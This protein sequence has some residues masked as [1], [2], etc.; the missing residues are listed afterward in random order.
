MFC[1]NC[2]TENADGDKFC[3]SCGKPLVEEKPSAQQK[4][5]VQPAVK[6]AAQPAATQ[7]SQ[8]AQATAPSTSGGFKQW[9]SVKKNKRIFIIVIIVL[10]AGFIGFN[11]FNFFTSR[12]SSGVIEQTMK[13]QR[14]SGFISSEFVNDSDYKFTDTR[15]NINEKIDRS[16]PAY[17]ALD[18]SIKNEIKSA[19]SDLYHVEWYGKATND[20]F[21]S[22]YTA[23]GY[24]VKEGLGFRNVGSVT[25]TWSTTKP[26]KGIDV[27]YLNNGKASAYAGYCISNTSENFECEFNEADQTC[28]AKQKYSVKYWWGSDSVDVTQKFT[29][30]E[31]KGWKTDGETKTDNL[32]TN[33]TELVDM[34]FGNSSIGYGSSYYSSSSSTSKTGSI[35]FKNCSQESVTAEYS[36]AYHPASGSSDNTIDLNGEANGTL[37]HSL[38]QTGFEFELKGNGVTLKGYSWYDQD[39][40]HTLTVSMDSTASTW[41]SSSNYYWKFSGVSFVQTSQSSVNGTNGNG[42]GTTSV[43]NGDYVLSNS[44]TSTL[45]DSDISGLTDDQLCIAQNEIW[46]RHGRKF[47]NNW[48]QDHFNKQSWYSGTI[49]PGDFLNK[50]TPTQTESDNASFLSNKLSSH[51]YDVNKVH[52]N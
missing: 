11:V 33:Y 9:L 27:F 18:S 1:M 45:T 49:E 46:A 32:V 15:V 16:A 40:L 36:L 31:N 24:F 7:T 42:Q 26:I 4:T 5:A 48:L 37:K 6:P 41:K 19:N 29:F 20:S 43:T 8:A 14:S 21:E 38:S 17:S 10:V 30:D 12:V 44:A 34:S 35:K 3:K 52:P 2:G 51:G 47:D 50:Y 28:T 25:K 39:N 23:E 22:E 13:D